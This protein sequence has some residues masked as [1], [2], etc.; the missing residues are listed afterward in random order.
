MQDGPLFAYRQMKRSGNLLA[1]EMQE[2][3]VEKFQ[4]LHNGL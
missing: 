2:L 1:D 4:S 3:A